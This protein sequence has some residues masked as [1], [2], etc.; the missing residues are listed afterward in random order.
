MPDILCTLP[1][2]LLLHILLSLPDLKALYVAILAS[3][4]LN[5][6]FHLDAHLI[7]KTVIA[8]S[9]PDELLSPVLVYMLLRE[10]LAARDASTSLDSE[11]LEAI[12]KDVSTVA[13]T[14][15]WSS[16]S[17]STL[18]HTMAQAV[19]IHD[20][21][22]H[23]LRSK[24]DYLGTIKFE[25]LANPGFRFKRPYSPVHKSPEGVLIDVVVPL[26]NPS[27]AEE[28]RA[29]S[30]LWLLTAGLRV[31]QRMTTPSTETLEGLLE[32]HR[33]LL[34]LEGQWTSEL[35]AEIVQSMSVG[36]AIR[37]SDKPRKTSL[38]TFQVLHTYPLRPHV[39]PHEY[40]GPD[41]APTMPQFSW[42]P[43]LAP[44]LSSDTASTWGDTIFAL[45]RENTELS[46]L[47]V[48]RLRSDSPLRD[49]D[50][51]VYHCL[52]FGF[53]DRRRISIEIGLRTRYNDSVRMLSQSENSFQ[54]GQRSR[55][56]DDMFRLFRV[57]E[58]QKERERKGWRRGF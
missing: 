52:G 55:L 3:P 51:D 21:A 31:A 42:I 44:D 50:W 2:P 20:V 49:S 53:W 47:R 27:W 58:Q 12:I 22:Y 54:E 37:P 9:L 16:I 43:T 38:E 11:G 10:R 41:Q 23:I 8:R 1:T 15:P 36:P 46:R 19:R 25:K 56:S 30:V 34:S 32:P 29:I 4:D 17:T 18:F 35:A 40:F 39:Q 13:K 33:V 7:F 5:A 14:R 28:T 6:V 48:Y 45:Q 26:S 24:L 57:Y